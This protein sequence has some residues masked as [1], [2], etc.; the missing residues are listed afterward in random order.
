MKKSSS[1][2][3]MIELIFV[4]VILG[5]LAAVALPK[6]MATRDDAKIVKIAQDIGTATSEI[7]TYAAAKNRIEN[8]LSKMSNALYTLSSEGR[9]VLDNNKTAVIS[10]GSVSNCITVKIVKNGNV[11]DLTV[12]FN[13]SAND[14]LCNKLQTLIDRQKYPMRILG[15]YV[16]E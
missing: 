15:Q 16:K 9:A 3:T 7:S 13:D 5:I 6:L 4:I 1:A 10:F 12:D 8:N 11:D 2:F 14:A